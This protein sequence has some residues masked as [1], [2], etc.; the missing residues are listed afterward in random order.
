MS[1]HVYSATVTGLD[2]EPIEVEADISFG[3]TRCL[4]VGLPDAAVQEARERVRSAIR[5]SGFKWPNT[6]VTVNLAPADLRKEGPAFD[7]PIALSVLMASRQFIVD[8]Q[9]ALF[10]GELSLEGEV[11]PVSGALPVALAAR[12][13][14]YRR[15]FV[16]ADNAAE[17]AIIDD[18][19]IHP[20]KCLNDVIKHY[21]GENLIPSYQ[22]EPVSIPDDQ[23]YP[24][25]F[26]QIKGQTRAKRALEIAAAGGHNVFLSGPPGS[27]KTM[28][29]KALISIMPPMDISEALDVTRIYSVAGLVT[30]DE[31][32]IIRRP[33]RSPHHTASS[34]ALIGGGRLPRP[35]EISLAHRGVL[36]LD[37]FPEFPRPVL[38]SLRQPLEDGTITIN[39]INGSLKFPARFVLV[40]A[41]NPCPCGYAS[42]PEIACRCSA[43]QIARY[44]QKISGPL[45]DRIDL[46]LTVPRV[47]VDDLVSA[48]AAEPSDV[49]RHRVVGARQ[50]Q[51]ERFRTTS[52][53]V[54]AEMDQPLI[55]RYCQLG[56]PAA[57]LL[58]NALTHMQLSARSYSRV[59]K[60]SRTIADLEAVD[61]ITTAHIAEALQYRTMG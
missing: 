23:T 43:W 4:I 5:H 46:H 3:L 52:I 18:I 41:Q 47:K 36:F 45:L 16:P 50:R 15:I 19:D 30:S 42:D 24:V 33:F 1:I 53:I 59:L 35:G 61:T 28:L 55:E 17:A 56:R 10:I 12:R 26:S 9:E 22:R 32:L 13:H 39:R 27:G 58:K 2:A 40:A 49:I 6:H 21:T 51:L 31:P 60:I 25:D 38:E 20:V 44:Q 37:E 29:A 48:Q 57:E 54:N 11:R 8:D 14:G 7:L 34:V